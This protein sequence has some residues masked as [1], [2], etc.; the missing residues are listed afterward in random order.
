MSSTTTIETFPNPRTGRDYHIVFDCPEFTCLCPMTG[1]PDFATITI[2]YVPDRLCV[3]LKSLKY[4]LFGFRQQGIFFEAVINRILDDLVE[5]CR[6]RRMT[7]TASHPRCAKSRAWETMSTAR[8]LALSSDARFLPWEMSAIG[9]RP[10]I[11]SGR[12][13]IASVG[14]WIGAPSA[15]ICTNTA[16]HRS[17]I[18]AAAVRYRPVNTLPRVGTRPGRIS[19]ASPTK[20]THKRE[21][22]DLL[23]VLVSRSGLRRLDALGRAALPPAGEPALL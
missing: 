17:F 3:E 9:S 19:R 4:Y 16:A 23:C 8:F 14:S 7:A 22:T 12:T 18:C 15:A 2:D 21:R 20:R 5:L 11:A 10:G 13:I 6:P 1:Q